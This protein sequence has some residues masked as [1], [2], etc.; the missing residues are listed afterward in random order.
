[1][2]MYNIS[3]IGALHPV[4]AAGY[5]KLLFSRHQSYM[6]RAVISK[7]KMLILSSCRETSRPALQC[8]FSSPPAVHQPEKSGNPIKCSKMEDW[9]P[10]PRT[11]IY[12][13]KGHERVMDDVPENAASFSQTYW[14]RNVD[15]VE[16]SMP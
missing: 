12:V 14:L 16:K 2:D 11:G 4:Q 3:K 13:P 1:M 7:T 10:H 9:L 5:N 6:A 8:H 15:G